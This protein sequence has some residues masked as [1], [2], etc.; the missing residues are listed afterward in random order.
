MDMTHPGALSHLH[1]AS[2]IHLEE[3]QVY[4]QEYWELLLASAKTK[5]GAKNALNTAIAIQSV[6][7]DSEIRN[8]CQNVIDEARNTIHSSDH[9]KLM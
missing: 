1:S 2:D 6:M 7:T 8:L 9:A 4:D 3:L 5:K